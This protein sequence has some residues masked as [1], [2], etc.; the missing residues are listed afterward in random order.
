MVMKSIPVF[1]RVLTD[2]SRM[3]MYSSTKNSEQFVSKLIK[4]IWIMMGVVLAV[5]VTY[6]V[7]RALYAVG[8]ARTTALSKIQ[9]N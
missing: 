2:R 8:A 6:D 5:E 4:Y 7:I 9:Q 3:K 1:V